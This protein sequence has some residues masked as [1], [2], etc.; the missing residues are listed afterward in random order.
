MSIFKSAHNESEI[1]TGGKRVVG[2]CTSKNKTYAAFATKF[3][4]RYNNTFYLLS[5]AYFQMA[6][7]RL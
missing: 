1:G 5:E 3:D 4:F 7:S 2:P 6:Q